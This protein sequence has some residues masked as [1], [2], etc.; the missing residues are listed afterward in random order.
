[1]VILHREREKERERASHREGERKRESRREREGGR[2]RVREREG[3]RE[4]GRKGKLHGAST[5]LIQKF[6]SVAHSLFLYKCTTP[7]R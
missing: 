6:I 4:G 3:G 7:Q 1:M 2:K 5:S